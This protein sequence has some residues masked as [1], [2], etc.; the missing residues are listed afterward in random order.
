MSQ[1][2]RRLGEGDV[3]RVSFEDREG[4]PAEVLSV[5]VFPQDCTGGTSGR[6]VPLPLLPLGERIRDDSRYLEP[7]AWESGCGMTVV[8]LTQFL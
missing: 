4:R 2:L 6:R 7:S 8:M 1:R 5:V 3:G